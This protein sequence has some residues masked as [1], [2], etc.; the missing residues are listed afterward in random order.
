M[1]LGAASEILYCSMRFGSLTSD[2][3]NRRAH[4]LPGGWWSNHEGG[5]ESVL[6]HRA[7]GNLAHKIAQRHPGHPG[8][9]RRRRGH[10][11]TAERRGE[12]AGH[13]RGR[14]P[15]WWYRQRTDQGS[16]AHA[17]GYGVA[18]RHET[19]QR[20]VQC[21][22]DRADHRAG[23]APAADRGQPC[24]AHGS[25][26]TSSAAAGSTPVV[27]I[28]AAAFWALSMEPMACRLAAAAASSSG[29]VVTKD[30]SFLLKSAQARRRVVRFVSLNW[31]FAPDVRK[32]NAPNPAGTICAQIEV[33]GH[34]CARST[35]GPKR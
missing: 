22:G 9:D 35:N 18:Q 28:A 19:A 4:T 29:C 23:G 8:R 15:A 31:G 30:I 16:F 5:T 20:T 7:A 13:W 27:G 6:G 25:A 1:L 12:G 21:A 32:G 34:F 24:A 14:G 11:C 3:G 2:A 10:R 17:C 26:D 33:R